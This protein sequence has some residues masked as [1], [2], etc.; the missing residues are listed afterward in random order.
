MKEFEEFK[1]AGR[2][3]KYIP[4]VSIT[5]EGNFNLNKAFIEKHVN[6]PN[7]YVIL[8]YDKKNQ[9]IAFKIL[10]KYKENSYKIRFLHTW[11]AT[12]SGRA[13]LKYNEVPYS[14]THSYKAIYD[15]KIGMIL[16]NLKKP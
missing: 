7:C 15:N 6:K 12:I 3:A 9:I 10:D 4:M 8:F 14:K 1:E 5:K 11:T 2:R 13:F 16:I